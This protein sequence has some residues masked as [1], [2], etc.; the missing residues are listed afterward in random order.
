MGRRRGGAERGGRMRIRTRRREGRADKQMCGS[1]LVTAAWNHTDYKMRGRM[2]PEPRWRLVLS[3]PKGSV[4]SRQTGCVAAVLADK[5]GRIGRRQK[6][7]NGRKT[8]VSAMR[9]TYAILRFL[10]PLTNPHPGISQT[11]RT[12]CSQMYKERGAN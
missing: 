4:Y 12:K 2:R 7:L 5:K 6:W 10:P 9:R 8:C 3:L 11:R 1:L